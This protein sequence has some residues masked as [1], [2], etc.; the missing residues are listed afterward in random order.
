MQTVLVI[1]DDEETRR[2]LRTVLISAGYFAHAAPTG[3]EGVRLFRAERIDLA[4]VDIWMPEKDGLETIMELRRMVRNARIIAM[5]GTV[6]AEGINPL[7]WAMR[8]GAVDQLQKPFS[9]DELLSAVE[10]AFSQNRN[11]TVTPGLGIIPH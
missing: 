2:L 4:I 3:E 10:N 6:K 1:D 7:S 5:T 9:S 8:L 11:T